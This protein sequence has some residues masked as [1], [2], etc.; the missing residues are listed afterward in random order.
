MQPRVGNRGNR[1]SRRRQAAAAL[2]LSFAGVLLAAT[3][4][5]GASIVIRFKDGTQVSFDLP[6][7]ISEIESLSIQPAGGSPAT[8][9]LKDVVFRDT[10]DAGI[11]DK[12][13]PVSLSGGSFERFAKVAD[14]KLVVSVPAGNSW[15]KTG[16][17]SKKPLFTVDEAMAT[18]PMKVVLD[19]DPQNPTSFLAARVPG[20]AADAYALQNCWFVWSGP[21][22]KRDPYLC[23]IN[24]RNRT[25]EKAVDGTDPKHPATAPKQVVFSV[26]PGT[27][28][29]SMSSGQQF[30][31]Q[32][33]WVA[34]GTPVYLHV[35]S[36][37]A[38]EGD[39]ASFSLDTVTV[40]R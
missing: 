24:T 6:Q 21:L 34:V 26:C 30:K 13:D 5:L 7:G 9:S 39:P 40:G 14:G 33:P 20:D 31:V 27:V 10:V 11:G 3:V 1:P 22:A 8:V 18:N 28:E 38:A 35:T 12:W 23:L 29:L 16:I 17:K 2:A 25:V 36:H 4:A 19:F 15:G 37:P 32:L